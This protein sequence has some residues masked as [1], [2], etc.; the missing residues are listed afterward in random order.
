MFHSRA[1]PKSDRKRNSTVCS[2]LDEHDLMKFGEI[3]KFLGGE[4]Q[5]VIVK[6]ITTSPR[7]L[8]SCAGNPC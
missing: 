8:L 3:E 1:H 4:E 7:S 2:Y 5:M 6:E